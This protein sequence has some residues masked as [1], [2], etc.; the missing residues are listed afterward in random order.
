MAQTFLVFSVV[1][2]V[3]AVAVVLP[4]EF[5]QSVRKKRDLHWL[6]QTMP[7]SSIIFFAVA[8]LKRVM[9]VGAVQLKNYTLQSRKIDEDACAH[10]GSRKW[11]QNGP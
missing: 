7:L 3:I 10:L 2:F 11:G 5:L 8:Q 1:V 4:F 9:P 6:W